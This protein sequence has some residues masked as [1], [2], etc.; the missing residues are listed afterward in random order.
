[1]GE[2]AK[3]EVG[4]PVGMVVTDRTG[5]PSDARVCDRTYSR[6]DGGEEEEPPPLAVLGPGDAIVAGEA[7]S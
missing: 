2:P 4:G 5:E 6:W 1:M 3:A 7:E